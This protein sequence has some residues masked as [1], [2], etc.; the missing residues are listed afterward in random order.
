MFMLVLL[1]FQAMPSAVNVHAVAAVK[2]NHPQVVAGMLFWQYVACT[3]T[4]PAF[5]VIML[6]KLSGDSDVSH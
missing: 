1:L 3:L 2:K 5:V 4:I 6:S